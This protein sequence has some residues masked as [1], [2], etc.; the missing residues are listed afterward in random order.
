MP[1]VSTT[2]VGPAA[3]PGM[4]GAARGREVVQQAPGVVVDRPHA[5]LGEPVGEHARHDLAVRE[6]VG[7]AARRA[8]VVLEHQP[9]PVVAAD[10]VAA[11][12]VQVLVVAA[13]RS[14]PPRAGS[15]APS[16]TRRRGTIPSWRI[17]CSW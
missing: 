9:A 8:Q 4:R 15:G 7:D 12:D 10:Q 2:T 6:H 13:R 17:S 1:G 11:D 3:R 14:R 5:Q 16:T